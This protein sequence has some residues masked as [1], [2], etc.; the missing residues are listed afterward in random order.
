MLIDTPRHGFH[1]ASADAGAKCVGGVRGELRARRSVLTL[2]GAKPQGSIRLKSALNTLA[3]ARDFPEGQSPEVA[4]WSGRPAIRRREYR[5]V[6]RHVGSSQ[7]ETSAIPCGRRKL[8]RG[9]SQERSRYEIR[10]GRAR[11]EE[12]VKR[13]IKPWRRTVAGEVNP[14]EVAPR[15]WQVLKGPE[16]Q[17]RCRPP[18][19]RPGR[20]GAIGI[21]S[22]GN[23]EPHE[24]GDSGV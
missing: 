6:K 8:R 18:R 10:P 14:R 19:K 15:V 17:E 13:V 20:L 24:S 12:T 23:A 5:L 16:A 1:A 21:D 9:K 2:E 3:G 7:M 11:G 22:G 4:G